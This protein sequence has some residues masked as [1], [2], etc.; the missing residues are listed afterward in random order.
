[1]CSL[2]LLTYFGNPRVLQYALSRKKA[3]VFDQ[4]FEMLDPVRAIYDDLEEMVGKATPRTP[5]PRDGD[6]VTNDTLGPELTR[7]SHKLSETLTAVSAAADRLHDIAEEQAQ[8]RSLRFH[9]LLLHQLVPRRHFYRFP[10]AQDDGLPPTAF[11]MS[12]KMQQLALR[13]SRFRRISSV[14]CNMDGSEHGNSSV[15]LDVPPPHA[16]TQLS[17]GGGAL[18]LAAAPALLATAAATA[19]G[20]RPQRAGTLPPIAE[21]CVDVNVSGASGASGAEWSVSVAGSIPEEGI[22][23]R[24]PRFLTP[25]DNGTPAAAPSPSQHLGA[26]AW[27]A[28][29]VLDEAAESV[30]LVSSMSTRVSTL[31]GGAAV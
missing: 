2:S 25:G 23:P 26:A 20:K 6:H 14:H 13:W 1:M 22:T 11:D 16:S 28:L 12:A 18:A 24:S 29:E 17:H 31:T 7:L 15:T 5:V 4:M 21:T 9:A 3:D 27:E 8:V 30:S 10:P 19:Q